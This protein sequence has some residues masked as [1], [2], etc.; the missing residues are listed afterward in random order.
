M[1]ADARGRAGSRL[2]AHGQA[3]VAHAGVGHGAAAFDVRVEAVAAR[4]VRA[5]KAVLRKVC[6]LT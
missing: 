2:R 4:D 6:S 1:P 5:G 3:A